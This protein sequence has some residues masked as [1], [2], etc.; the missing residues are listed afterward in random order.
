MII[1]RSNPFDFTFTWAGIRV[2]PTANG[3]EAAAIVELHTP[4]LYVV[5][6]DDPITA[7]VLSPAT[8]ETIA[9]AVLGMIRKLK[10]HEAIPA[11]TDASGAKL[12]L[13]GVTLPTEELDNLQRVAD[14]LWQS[15][16]HM[17]LREW[18]R[19]TRSGLEEWLDVQ[20]EKRERWGRWER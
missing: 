16:P 14:K 3:Y 9:D 1:P 7:R 15:P 18:Q 20:D 4:R 11:G 19:A 10:E 17:H 13:E 8:A 5:T 12:C 2:K 6:T